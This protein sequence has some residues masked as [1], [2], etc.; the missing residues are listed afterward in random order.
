[1]P[2]FKGFVIL[3]FKY[4]LPR[5]WLQ[6]ENH[7][8]S[9]ICLYTQKPNLKAKRHL[10]MSSVAIGVTVLSCKEEPTYAQLIRSMFRQPLHVS[11]VSRPII[12]R[13]SRMCTT[14]GTY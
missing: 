7:R 1:M 3:I 5:S 14:I 11:G 8:H 4:I 10:A 12:R 9:R 2:F 6:A 13:Y